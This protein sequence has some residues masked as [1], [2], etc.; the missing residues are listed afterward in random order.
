MLW[1]MRHHGRGC[2]FAH[3]GVDTFQLLITGC[4]DI[5]LAV[6]VRP[7]A[8]TAYVSSAPPIYPATKLE[9]H[10]KGDLGV[11]D[12]FECGWG[13][14]QSVSVIG[15]SGLKTLQCEPHGGSVDSLRCLLFGY[16][17]SLLLLSS[18][19]PALVPLSF[20]F[21]ALLFAL[22]C[23]LASLHFGHPL[24]RLLFLALLS[25]LFLKQRLNFLPLFILGIRAFDQLCL[26]QRRTDSLYALYFPFLKAQLP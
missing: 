6:V 25:C 7:T 18:Q 1:D 21:T 8:S 20:V 23:F 2:K 10:W 15:S 13:E 4:F 17:S 16:P 24:L 22:F 5:H 12:T 14:H 3:A 9:Y 11:H 19:R 26:F